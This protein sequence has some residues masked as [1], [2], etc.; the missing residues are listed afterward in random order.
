MKQKYCVWVTRAA[1]GSIMACLALLGA[2]LYSPKVRVVY[3]WTD[4]DYFNAAYACDG[5][6]FG[7][8]GDC[9]ANPSYP[10][11][12]DESQCR[13]NAGSSYVDCLSAIPSPSYEPDFCAMARAANDNC[14]LQYGPDSGN[15][16]LGA[17]MSCRSASGIDQCQ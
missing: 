13:Y 12:P 3:A 16:D 10:Y 14:I 2:L 9:R 15:T 8:L 6:Y 1:A 17:M 5:D 7:T 11:N 4:Y